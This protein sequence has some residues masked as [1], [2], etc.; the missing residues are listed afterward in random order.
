MKRIFAWIIL[1]CL[2]YV[3][4]STTNN[5][6]LELVTNFNYY[7][8]VWS[9]NPG[10]VEARDGIKAI[11][12]DGIRIA[13][14]LALEKCTTTKDNN[15]LL[16]SYLRIFDDRKGEKIKYM[17]SNPKV[18]K[19]TNYHTQED[20]TLIT[21]VADVEVTSVS[22]HYKMKNIFYI[23]NNDKIFFIGDYAA[24]KTKMQTA[25]KLPTTSQSSHS[26]TNNST[27]TL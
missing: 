15:I 16:E 2:P 9:R 14:R 25:Q 11:C 8:G 13:D 21:I 3:A 26:T 5:K 6:A 4:N 24:E 12:D 20:P 18:E 10:D 17:I 22:L 19:I 1:V 7:I 23:K 27:P